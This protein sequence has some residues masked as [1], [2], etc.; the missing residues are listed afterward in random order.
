MSRKARAAPKLIAVET[1]AKVLSGLNIQHWDLAIVGDGSGSGW[2]GGAGWASVLIERRTGARKTFYGS[3]NL[4]TVTV[5]EI[6]PWLYPLLWYTSY[7]GP[8]K[9]R[10]VMAKRANKPLRVCVLSD[11]DVI[12]RG[13]NF[14]PSRKAHQALWSLL[15]FYQNE[16]MDITFHHIPRD[17]YSLH[18]LMDHLSRQS[19]LSLKT[20]QPATD[21]IMQNSFPGLPEDLTVYDLN[22]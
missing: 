8:G 20:A 4:G 18:I 9:Q 21:K 10:L 2:S 22:P 6:F 11:S 19:R 16:G 17:T 14:P 1:L 12:V 13:G 3:F 15:S 7:E 5:A